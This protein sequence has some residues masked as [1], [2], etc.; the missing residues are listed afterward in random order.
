MSKTRVFPYPVIF[1]CYMSETSFTPPRVSKL[2]RWQCDDDCSS[3]RSRLLGSC[4]CSCAFHLDCSCRGVHRNTCPDLN[5]KGSDAEVVPMWQGKHSLTNA[6]VC[7]IR[8]P[9]TR[10]NLQLRSTRLPER[11]HDTGLQISRYPTGTTEHFES[12]S[13][14]TLATQDVRH[15]LLSHAPQLAVPSHRW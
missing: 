10:T 11:A 3:L 12:I 8:G 13:N 15:R 9:R 4:L 2:P 1:E 5:G 14:A 6:T 7:V